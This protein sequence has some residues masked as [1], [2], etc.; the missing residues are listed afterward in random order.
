[1]PGTVRP[2][3]ARTSMCRASLARSQMPA[4]KAGRRPRSSESTWGMSTYTT[5]PMATTAASRR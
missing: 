2:I 1:M 3:P 4:T 5:A